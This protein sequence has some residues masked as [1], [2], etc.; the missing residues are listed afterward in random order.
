MKLYYF[1]ISGPCRAVW[2][3]L[4]EV[5]IPFEGIKI[6]L[7]QSEQ[8][9]TKFTE[10]SPMHSVPVIKDATITL[11]EVGAILRYLANKFRLN[12]WYP[13]ETTQR[14]KVDQYLDW[15]THLRKSSVAALEIT[16]GLRT[17][18]F[19]FSAE[20]DP[21]EMDKV[22][23]V[24]KNYLDCIAVLE[25]SFLDKTDFL[26]GDHMT[27]A[28]VLAVT[29]ITFHQLMNTELKGSAPK[30]AQWYERVTSQ[31]QH[32][33]SIHA[34]FEQFAKV[35][36][37]H[38]KKMQENQIKAK[39]YGK[40]AKGGQKP[41]DV[42]HTVYFP[43]NAHE[44][45]LMFTDEA[46]LSKA[47]QIPCKIHAC[48]GG[49]FSY[50]DIVSG[51]TLIF[52]QDLKILQSWRSND[53][54]Q[55]VFST[56]K[57][58]LEKIEGGTELTMTQSDVPDAFLQKTDAWWSG[59]FW[60]HLEA[61]LTRNIIQQVF[62]ENAKPREIYELLMDSA[63]LTKYTRTKCE[64]GRG[65]G[66]DFTLYDNLITGKNLELVTDTKIV[67]KWRMS[68]WPTWHFSTV[69]MEIKRVAGG[70]DLMFSQVAV[71]VDKY[72]AVQDGWDKNFWRKMQREIQLSKM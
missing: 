66:G 32:W 47:I 25:S 51:T 60:K 9:S 35:T 40:D 59:F 44:V 41:P 33:K 37:D 65:V 16:T 28:D 56:V 19:T 52:L 18:T 43:T 67:Q 34:E 54:P 64:I 55:N 57:I 68:D 2:L 27:I 24:M 69:T 15:H 14:A 22:A 8:M 62:F 70:T 31:L 13:T 11:H 50:G 10:L 53:W 12:Q 26:A 29:E 49:K 61:V 46:Q 1:P 23:V 71:P 58:T 6:D 4:K 36:A 30:V 38:Q 42:S 20:Q 7:T 39:R 21:N 17:S 72:R 5:Q 63:K 3:F 45:Y 48:N